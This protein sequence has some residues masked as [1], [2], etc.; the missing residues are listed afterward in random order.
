[1]K[2]W[3]DITNAPHVRFFRDI[4]TH[5]QDE[6]EDVIITAR[7]FGDIHRLMNLFGFE[8]T[9]IGKHGVTLAEKLLESTKRA[10]K[11]SK[12]IAEEKPDVG[13]SKHSIELPRVTFGLGIPSV[14]VLDNEHAIAANKLTL[15]L[16]DHII[17]PEVIDL[18]D[19]MKTGADPNRITRY[20]G[21]LR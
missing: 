13:L 15:P 17:M 12:F 10:Y 9:S 19:I 7:K 21:H 3:I 18:W 14:Y 2:V 11:L 6:G 5:L 8:F 4:I 1:M 20:G 16:C